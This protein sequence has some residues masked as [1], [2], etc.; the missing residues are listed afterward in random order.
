M[1]LDF[2]IVLTF[3]RMD[4]FRGAYGR[5]EGGRAK[6]PTSLKSVRHPTKMKIGIVITYLKKIPKYMNHVTPP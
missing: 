2:K 5:W 3:F 1:K 4:L 6:R